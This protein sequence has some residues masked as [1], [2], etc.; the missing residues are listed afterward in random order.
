YVEALFAECKARV[1]DQI[2]AAGEREPAP[3]RSTSRAAPV[4]APRRA[5]IRAVRGS[6]PQNGRTAPHSAP[7]NEDGLA[8]PKQLNY[9][10]SLGS[11]NGM[12][13][14]Q[15]AAL[16]EETFGKREL[17]ELTKKEASSL[18]DQLRSEAA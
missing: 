12:S 8:S 1:E 2:A 5:P 13:Y 11:Q 6:V 9:L 17:R 4:P 18:I 16:A 7:P 10:R 3:A 14:G 15:V